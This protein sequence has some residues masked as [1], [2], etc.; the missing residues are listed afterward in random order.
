MVFSIS[1]LAQN[2]E[3]LRTI[4]FSLISRFRSNLHSKLD[5]FDKIVSQLIAK[6]IFRT[7]Y[8]LDPSVLL[9][10]QV[11]IPDKNGQAN[12]RRFKV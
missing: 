9:I 1:N 8:C 7:N 2:L 6:L 3:H 12:K 10:I 11:C 4:I 5:I